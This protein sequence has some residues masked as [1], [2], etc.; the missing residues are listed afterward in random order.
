MTLICLKSV[1][2]PPVFPRGQ[3]KA[4]II[5]Y[6]ILESDPNASQTSVLLSLI[7]W[8]HSFMSDTLHF[9]GHGTCCLFC[10]KILPLGT[11]SLSF[12]TF[13]FKYHLLWQFYL[14][15]YPPTFLLPFPS[16]V[17]PITNL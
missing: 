2:H 9:K 17:S 14:K 4:Q 1:Y 7:L 5:T 13:L 3:V 11:H 15:V 10:L 12:F 8:L 6:K 16:L